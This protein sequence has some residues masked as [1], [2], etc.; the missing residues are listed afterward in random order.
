MRQELLRFGT[1]GS[2]QTTSASG[3]PAAIRHIREL[4][5][6]H[7]EIAWTHSVSVTEPTCLQIRETAREARVSLSVH[8]PYYINFNSQTDDKLMKSNERLFAAAR[9]GFLAGATDIVFHP[10]SYHKLP[11]ADVYPI[12]RDRLGAVV[13][14][15][16][17]EGVAVTLRPETM[18]K[19]SMFGSLE[20]T[21]KLS[22]EIPN[23]LPCIDWAHL[24]ARNANGSFNTREEFDQ[25]LQMLESYLGERGLKQVH[26]H[27][28]GIAYTPKGEKAH[29]PMYESP[30]R[31]VDLLQAFIAFGLAGTVGIEAPEPFHTADAL[32]FQALYR[33][34]LNPIHAAQ[35]TED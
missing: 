17:Q 10:G 16:T 24:Y 4:G 14:R 35:E 7:L 27:L 31:F 18:G 15:L 11:P 23:V 1:V 32:H 34:L 26:F 30:Q 28:S 20:E 33:H 5:L 21:L 9:A 8:A 3:T 6:D 25:A 22:H 19:G 12:V 13:H 29:I 2:P